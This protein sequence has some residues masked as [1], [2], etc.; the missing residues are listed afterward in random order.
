MVVGA[1]FGQVPAI[2]KAKEMGLTVVTID[3]NPEALGMKLADF[4]YSTDIIDVKAAIK[5]AKKHAIDGVMTMQSDL[6]IPTVG[7]IIDELNIYGSGLEVANRCSNKIETRKAFK[8]KNVPQPNYEI[9]ADYNEA[10]NAAHKMGFPCIIKAPDSSGSRG[11]TKVN[12]VEDVYSAVDEAFKYSRKKQILVES[13]VSGLEIGA[14]A[15]SINGKC[16]KVLVHNDM[17]TNPPYMVPIGHSFP[18]NLSIEEEKVVQEAVADAVD[19]LGI[20]DG[21]SNIDLI[22]DENNKPMIIEIGARIGATCL[23]ELVE[24]YT[25]INWVEQAIKACLGLKINLE[26]KQNQPVVAYII[27]SPKDGVLK[28]FDIPL[29]I[30]EHPQVKEVEITAKIGE[31]VNILRKGT[32]RIGKI[33]VTAP[34]VNEANDLAL[35]LIK[36]I[37]IEVD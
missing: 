6:P 9:V 16:E 14:Q 35:N 8:L 26:E 23:P 5:I 30:S 24:Y 11:V 27:E 18:I 17:V 21:P 3:K 25:G 33:I 15:F 13:Y 29:F 4:A 19:A 22:L 34:S 20:T 31:E 37:K 7:A 10:T 36:Q 1:G 28:A 2:L 32:D 12:K